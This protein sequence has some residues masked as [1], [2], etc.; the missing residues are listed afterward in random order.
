MTSHT[1]FHLR[2]LDAL[3]RELDAVGLRL[4]IE[5]DL[6]VLAEQVPIAGR[7]TPNRFVDSAH[8]GL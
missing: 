1:R 6:S 3:R 4:P 5:E 8:G 7:R 2:D